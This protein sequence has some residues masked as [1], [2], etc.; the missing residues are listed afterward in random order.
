MGNAVVNLFFQHCVNQTWK[1]K[2]IKSLV[3]MS[4]IYAGAGIPLYSMVTPTTYALPEI[5][6]K[7]LITD[8]L[9]TCGGIAWL[10]PDAE[11]WGDYVFMK[12]PAANYTAR[13]ISEILTKAKLPGPLEMYQAV[14]NLTVRAAP[15]VTVHCYYGTDVNTSNY[16]I[17]DNDMFQ[18][19]P[20]VIPSSGDGSVPLHSLEVCNSWASQQSKPVHVFPMKNVTHQGILHNP[21]MI[22]QIISIATGSS[23]PSILD[24]L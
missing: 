6:G 22:H 8:T 7:E 10:F 20:Q 21:W 19:D 12:T 2:Y 18:G 17:Y 1:D 9:R 24:T 4:G 16:F 3:S 5:V 11:Y 23:R 14:K 13:N 15:N